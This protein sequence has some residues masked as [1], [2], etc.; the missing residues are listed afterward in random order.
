[1][2]NGHTIIRCKRCG[3]TLVQQPNRYMCNHCLQAYPVEDGIVLMEEKQEEIDL[4]IG[5]NLLDLHELRNERKYYGAYIQSDVEYAARLH[6]AN[7]PDFH[8]KLLSP[9]ISDSIILDL[10]CGQL[11]YIDS[12]SEARPETFYGLDL[13]LES[14]VIAKR[15]FKGTFP[16]ILVRHGVED[17]PFNNASVDIGISSEVLEHLDNPK[18]YLREIYRVVKDGGYLSLSTPCVSMYFYPHDLLRMMIR[19]MSWYKMVNCHNYWEEALN[20]HPGLRPDI[21]REWVE[22]AGFS[23]ERH[24]TRLWFYHT[25]L[26]LVWRL[27][28]LAERMGI[29]AAGSIFA[30]YL[31]LMDAVLASNIP[32]IKWFGIR[33]FILCRKE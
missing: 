24:E 1:M 14:L 19:P 21:L 33:Q 6:S 29:S 26:R 3:G 16:L 10:G 18:C 8:A 5:D 30:R 9:Y 13:S 32:V 23:I 28:S 4:R 22:E 7:F 2:V 15:N 27:F 11:P 25:P 12:F 17:V 20:W 31:R